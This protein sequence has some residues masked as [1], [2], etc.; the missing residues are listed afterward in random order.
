MNLDKAML[1]DKA[2]ITMYAD[3]DSSS[4]F[5]DGLEGS[6][7]MCVAAV[8]RFTN[9]L[10]PDLQDPWIFCQEDNGGLN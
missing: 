1:M 4:S 7:S 10:T 3:L 6:C 5:I 8:G 9:T 2:P